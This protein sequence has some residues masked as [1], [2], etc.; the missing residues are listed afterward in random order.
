MS[1]QP[2]NSILQL[3]RLRLDMETLAELTELTDYE[4][5][6]VRGGVGGAAIRA[7]KKLRPP[8]KTFSAGCTTDL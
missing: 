6:E 7:G 5:E 2:R 1:D 3:A 8:S 4:A